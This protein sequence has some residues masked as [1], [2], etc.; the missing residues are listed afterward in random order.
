M[1]HNMSQN[2][3]TDSPWCVVELREQ[4]LALTLEMLRGRS[5]KLIIDETGDKKK[6]DDTDYVARLYIG[7]LGKIDKGIVSVNAIGV[8]GDIT[9]PLMFK[10]S[11]PN[12]TL[13]EGDSYKTKPQLAAEIIQELK[14]KNFNFDLVLADSLYGESDTFVTVLNKF[15]LDYV[16]AIR[17]NHAVILPPGQNVIRG[18]WQRFYR[19]FNDGTVEY[20]YLREI[21]YGSR[22]I[23]TFWQITTDTQTLP[24]NQ[25]WYVMTSLQGD[26]VQKRRIPLWS[27][28][29]G[30]NMPSSKPKM[31][32]D[33]QT[34]V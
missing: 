8:L 29:I 21:Q 26:L 25:T 10:I 23:V 7:N 15:R 34:S 19:I 24:K 12:P 11:K 16:L 3:L 1:M 32:W 31:N 13:K 5:I 17:S 4:R 2:F 20:R 18:D 28:A 27:H 14:D 6:G 33:G 9:L 22:K 30:W